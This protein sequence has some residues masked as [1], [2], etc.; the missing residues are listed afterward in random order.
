MTYRLSLEKSAE[1]RSRSSL[2]PDESEPHI[3]AGSPNMT[4]STASR[5]PYFQ[6]DLPAGMAWT[7]G[8]PAGMAF[9]GFQERFAF[10]M[11]R[12]RVFWYLLPCG[13]GC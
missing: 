7:H 11:E 5:E 2:D 1:S 3:H 12:G 8:L 4:G 10:L 6:T 9:P 13:R